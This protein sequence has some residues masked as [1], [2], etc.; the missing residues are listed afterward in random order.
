MPYTE[1]TI[2]D[3]IVSVVLDV[4]SEFP[5]TTDVMIVTKGEAGAVASATARGWIETL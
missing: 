3:G 1:V 5:A 4:P 2:T